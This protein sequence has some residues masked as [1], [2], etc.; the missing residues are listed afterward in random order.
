MSLANTL[1]TFFGSALIILLIFAEC[2]FNY[3]GNRKTK[4]IFCTV[5]IITL[6]ALA[7]SYIY[8]Y[9][10]LIQIS[11]VLALINKLFWPVI[12]A[13][14]LYIYL[15]IILKENR[16]D[17]LT[18]LD[19]RY[20]FFD[21]F[22]KISRNKNGESWS[23]AMIDINNFKSINDIYG[24]L[25]GDIAL[26]NLAKAIKTCSRKADFSARYGGDEFILITRSEKDLVNTINKIEEQLIKIN[27]KREKL[28]DLEISY[29]IE[30]FITDGSRPT[31]EY[32]S[33]IDKLMLK[34]NKETR[35][36]SDISNG[37]ET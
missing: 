29:E 14:Y 25:E 13:F 3:S 20:S 24:H 21:F 26:R 9:F 23:I 18:G 6:L 10:S 33:H 7:I 12:A 4:K 2:V 8:S 27:E 19:N 16:T 11:P 17:T 34:H 5:L 28:Y 35:R 36:A 1:N 32:L 37:A 15:F 30:T 31:D 22:N